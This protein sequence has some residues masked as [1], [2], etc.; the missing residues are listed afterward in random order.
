MSLS[1]IK[2][3]AN[4]KLYPDKCSGCGGCI[5]VCPHNVLIIEDHKVAFLDQDN[6][7]ECGGCM[8]NCPFDAI[9]VKTGVG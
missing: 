6:C 3:V 1:Y 5:E 8:K 7:I 2:G 9:V 4:I